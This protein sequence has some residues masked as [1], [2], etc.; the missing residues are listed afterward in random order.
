[1]FVTFAT[2]T[3]TKFSLI[4]LNLNFLFFS[5][6]WIVLYSCDF[7]SMRF[8]DRRKSF[9]LRIFLL[10][11]LFMFWTE[12]RTIEVIVFELFLDDLNVENSFWIKTLTS[13]ANFFNRF[14]VLD[15][16]LLLWIIENLTRFAF[17]DENVN[18]IEWFEITCVNF[19]LYWN[20][21]FLKL[22]KLVLVL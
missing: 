8:L 21:L 5:W 22:F 17:V 6:F 3:L 16:R 12:N 1:M 11:W 15:L 20:N 7:A 9:L 2:L 13:C 14:D 19:L 10:F 18:K 4:L